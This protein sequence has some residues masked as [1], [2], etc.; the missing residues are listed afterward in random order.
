MVRVM[1]TANFWDM[2]ADGGDVFRHYGDEWDVD[3][4][5][6]ERL[7]GY[8]IASVIGK[9]KAPKPEPKAKAKAKPEPKA[10]AKAKAKPKAKPKAKGKE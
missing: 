2:D 9:A 1:A 8:R 7:V 4:E 5:R 10:K 3:E 6:A